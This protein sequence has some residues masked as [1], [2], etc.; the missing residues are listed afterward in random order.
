MSARAPTDSRH[1]AATL[2]GTPDREFYTGTDMARVKSVFDLRARAH[3]LMP[4]FVLEYL[5]GGAEDE[6]SL[7][8]ERECYA[9]WRFVPRQLVDVSHRSI[10]TDI[11]GKPA[12]MPLAIAPT[13]LN[14][15]FMHHAD[16]ALGKAAAAAGVPYCQSTMSNDA[17][18]DVAAAAPG[19]RH[20][21]QLYVFGGDEVWQELL[22]RADACGC[23]ALLLTTNSQI[24]GDRVWSDRDQ[25]NGKWP[26]LSSMANAATHPRWFA[27]SIAH[28]MPSFA[29]VVDFI[30][31][32]HRGFFES[33]QWIREQMPK[34]LSWD[35][36]AKIRE[37]WKK[38]FL[39]K[40]LLHPEDIRKAID[41]GVDGV[42]LGT[43]GGRQEDWSVAA[44][45]VLPEA[46]RIARG[47]IS[48]MMSGGIRRG[49][50]LLKAL[51]LGA[52][53][54]LAGR[55]PLYGLCAAGEQGARR[56]LEILHDEARD[57]MG[58]MGCARISDLTPEMIASISRVAFPGGRRDQY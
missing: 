26:T 54:V 42:I 11:L 6:A 25:V 27:G 5:E 51:A 58:Q 32:E 57:D 15:L 19:L 48:V 47:R 31:K 7:S 20:W 56:A 12:K 9:E 13:G 22:R 3:H 30:P 52:D 24:F 40:G 2:D 16:I 29:N 55:T 17:M 39:L 43:H 46:V 50:D 8:R 4:R 41:S 18:E 36:V 45:D 37:R 23:E 1:D 53:A 35:M 49:T 14:A 38:P 21:W 44:L 28:G 34:S 10:E 33:A